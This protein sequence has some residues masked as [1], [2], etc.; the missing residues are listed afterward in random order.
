MWFFSCGSVIYCKIL[1]LALET[2]ML[3]VQQKIARLSYNTSA[4]SLYYYL[5]ILWKMRAFKLWSGK[6]CLEYRGEKGQIHWW[7]IKLG[8][9]TLSFFLSHNLG[10]INRTKTFRQ[11]LSIY[12]F[13]Y[14]FNLHSIDPW[15][16]PFRYGNSQDKQ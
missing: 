11:I 9:S 14:L 6:D 12:L 16:K 8:P 7:L 2:I 5:L 3:T 13:I 15:D 10:H 1:L 4:K